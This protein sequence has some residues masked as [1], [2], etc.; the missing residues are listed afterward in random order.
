MRINVR[1][2]QG[3]GETLEILSFAKRSI[4]DFGGAET[5]S[6]DVV[7]TISGVRCIPPLSDIF[8]NANDNVSFVASNDNNVA[9]VAVAA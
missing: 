3:Y 4:T 8:I 1:L 7:K 2:R 9:A 6:T 5:G